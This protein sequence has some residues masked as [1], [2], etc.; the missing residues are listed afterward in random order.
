[1]NFKNG[2]WKIGEFLDFDLDQASDLLDDKT[3]NKIVNNLKK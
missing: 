3:S 2:E 1:M